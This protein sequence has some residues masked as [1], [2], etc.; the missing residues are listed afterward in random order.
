MNPELSI[1]IINSKFMSL[2]ET[3]QILNPGNHFPV[4]RIGQS[5]LFWVPSIGQSNHFSVTGIGLSNRFWV[6]TS[7]RILNKK[8]ILKLKSWFFKLKIMWNMIQDLHFIIYVEI[9]YG[10][11]IPLNNLKRNLPSS[12]QSIRQWRS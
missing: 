11:T 12:I 2:A 10:E 1:F 3:L 8:L 9:A 7:T 5:N 6:P 4:T